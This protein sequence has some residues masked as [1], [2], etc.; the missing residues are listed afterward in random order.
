MFEGRRCVGVTFQRG[1][2][3]TEAR[4]DRE[5]IVAGGAVN[6]PHILQVSGI[7]PAAHLQSLGIPVVHDLPGVGANLIDHYVVRVVHR[8]QGSARR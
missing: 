7:G 4:A 5:V 3:L 2:K 1:G 8:V 6:S